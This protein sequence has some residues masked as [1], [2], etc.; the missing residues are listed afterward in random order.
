MPE[1]ALRVDLITH[2]LLEHLGLREATVLFALPDLHAIAGDAKRTAGGRLQRHF[3]QVIRKRAEQLLGQPRRAQQPLALGAIGDDNLRLA[4][5]HNL[6]GSWGN[7][8][9]VSGGY[10]SGL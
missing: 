10:N 8:L 4:H 6:I 2:P 3:A 9:G 1:V 7:G 5:G